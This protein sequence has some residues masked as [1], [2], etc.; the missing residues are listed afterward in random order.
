MTRHGF[1]R[2]Y[3]FVVLSMR[4]FCK[5]SPFNPAPEWTAGVFIVLSETLYVSVAVVVLSIAAGWTDFLQSKGALRSCLIGVFL[6]IWWAHS[7]GESRFV[8]RFEAEFRRLPKP[9]RIAVTVGVVALAGLSVL[10]FAAV[11]GA[12]H[13]YLKGAR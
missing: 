3:A 8:H 13:T 7:R 1:Q 12:A 5:L 9:Q 4:D 6:V 11:G 10:V 2:L